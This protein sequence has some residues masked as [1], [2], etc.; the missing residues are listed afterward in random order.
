[1]NTQQTLV[2]DL[3]RLG[4]NSGD[5]VVVHSSLRAIGAIED[6]PR[7]LVSA[8]L[9]VLGPEG[10]LV[11]P[12]FSYFASVFDPAVEPS[13]TG[14]LTEIVRAWPGAVR[15]HHPS[16]SV[17]ALG[18]RASEFCAGHQL[19]GGLSAGSPLD[20][21][22]DDGGWVM[23]IAVGHNRNSTV[24]TGECHAPAPYLDLPIRFGQPATAV[25]RVDGVEST[26]DLKEIPGCSTGFGAIEGALRRKG[27]IRDGMLGR[28]NVQLMRGA[29][30]IA[31]AAEMV[32]ADATTLLCNNPACRRCTTARAEHGRA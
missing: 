2:D 5:G 6:G 22:A 30:V 7:T 28:A 24:H 9:D 31:T 1:L 15:S 26:I 25:L 18:A 21:L 17:T 32:R 13:L 27:A 19:V 29:D 20:R 23:L 11:V 8:F 4:L 16:H 3:R 14:G 10:L 12:T